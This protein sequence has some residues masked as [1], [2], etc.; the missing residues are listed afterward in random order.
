LK[1]KAQALANVKK[2]HFNRVLVAI[3]CNAR[4]SFVG[5]L[6]ACKRPGWSKRLARV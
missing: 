6:R 5:C 1:R 4:R 3:C 2:Y